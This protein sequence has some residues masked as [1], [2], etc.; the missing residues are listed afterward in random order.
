MRMRTLVAVLVLAIAT[1]LS[2]APKNDKPKERWRA[3]QVIVKYKA[4]FA[5]AADKHG[6]KSA[7]KV[8]G[9][10]KLKGKAKQHAD[11]RGLD[12]IYVLNLKK[13]DVEATVAALKNDPAVEYA[14]P[15]WTLSF[16]AVP[17][18]PSY[19]SQWGLAK[20]GAPAAWDTATSGMGVVVGVVDTGIDLTHPDLA[21]NL[22]TNAGEIAGNNIDDDGNGFVDD[23]HGFDFYADHG[24]PID[25]HG[26]GTMVAGVIGA[27]GNNATGVSGVVW[28]ARLAALKIGSD[29]DVHAAVQAIEY[30]NMMGFRITSNSWGWNEG[31]QSF[32]LDDVIAAA[33][34]AGHLFV[35]AA[36]NDAQN[37][38]EFPFYPS[39]YTNP[40]VISVTATTSSDALASFANYGFT[41]VDLAAPGDGI[42][43]TNAGGGYTTVSGTSLSAPFV[44]GA[45][46]LYWTT[47]PSLT[48]AAVRD[49]LM[50]R[51][52]PLPALNGRTVSGGRLNV[53]NLFDSDAVAPDAITDLTV[54]DFTHRS[55][56]VRF[57][58]TGDDGA[59][60]RASRY[61][62]RVSTSP[63][64]A[65]SFAT[66]TPLVGEPIPA[67]PA[68]LETFKL[69]GIQPSTVYYIA[70]KALDNAGNAGALSNV[71]TFTTPRAAVL[72]DDNFEGGARD[73]TVEGTDGIGGPSLWHLQA[74][75][76]GT[77]RWQYA[78]AAGYGTDYDTGARNWGALVSRELDLTQARDTRL[79]FRQ[80]VW[81]ER[82]IGR[83]LAQVQVSV[84]GGAWTTILAKQFTGYEDAQ[85]ELDLSAYDGQ[86]IRIR[87]FIDTVDADDNAHPGWTLDDV[88][89]DATSAN[90]PPSVS[91]NAI[92]AVTEDQGATLSATGNDPE[93]A[94]LE[95]KW[96]FGDGK[97]AYTTQSSVAH[98]WTLPGNYTVTVTAYDGS[99]AS[100]AATAAVVPIA[101]NDRPVAGIE[102]GFATPP[103]YEDTPYTI[104]WFSSSDE[105]DDPLTCRFDY[106][107][108]TTDSRPCD[109]SWP[110]TWGAPGVYTI[111]LV[112]NDG[113]LD[114]L[115]DT[116]QITIL[117]LS[118]DKPVART[119][120][121]LDAHPNESVTF[122]GTASTDEETSVAS[123]LWNFGDGT[124]A[125]TATAQ[126]SFSTPGVK[127]VSLVV[128][129]QTG[130]ASN[131]AST[132][133]RVCGGASA[134]L[135][136]ST[137]YTCPGAEA[138][139][140]INV[141]SGI[142]P[143]TITW[144]DGYTQEVTSLFNGYYAERIVTP[145]TGGS[146][147]LASI[148]DFLGCAGTVNTAPAPVVVPSATLP[149]TTRHICPGQST[150]IEPQLTG[151]KPWTLTW[152]DG[153]VQTIPVNGDARRT[154]A[155]AETTVYTITSATCAACAPGTSPNVSG[156]MTVAV[157]EP[158]AAVVSGGGAS[159]NG[160][161]VPVTVTITG[162][163]PPFS[164][165]W[166][167]AN[168]S[169][170]TSSRTY[171]TFVAPA[172][173]TTYT[174]RV[175]SGSCEVDATGS[176]TVT[177]W[178]G[179][180]PK[181]TAVTGGQSI[182]TGGSATLTAT[183]QGDGP[184]TLTWSDGFVQTVTGTA[185]TRNV[186]PASST[187]YSVASIVNEAGC[188]GTR[189][190]ST[191]VSVAAPPT[192]LVRGGGNS[193]SG[194]TRRINVDL[195]GIGPYTITWS[196]GVTETV[197]SSFFRDLA[198]ATTT[199]YSLTSVTDSRC[200]GTVSGSATINVSTPVSVSVT[201]GGPSCAGAPV[202]VNASISGGTAPYTV[203]WS[204]GFVQTV[205][206]PVASR[207]VTV[208]QTTSFS[209]TSINSI[210]GTSIGGSATVWNATAPTAVVSGGGTFC[211]GSNATLIVQLS[212]GGPYN[213]TWSDGFTQT[214]STTFFTRQVSPA[215]ATTYTITSLSNSTCS[216][217]SSGSATATPTV[218]TAVVSGG[219]E[220]CNGAPATL[221]A[222]LS[223]QGLPFTLTWS[224]GYVQTANSLTATR[225]VTPG[226]PTTYTLTSVRNANGCNGTSSGSAVVTP[227]APLSAAVSGGGAVCPGGSASIT[228]S[229]TGE[230]GP[231]T[232]TWSDGF[233]QTASTSTAT[234]SV[235]P[236]SSTTYSVSSIT[237]A[238]G[239]IG[240]ASGSASVSVTP[241][242]AAVVSGGGT[243]C[244]GGTARINV[245]LTGVGPFT[246]TWANGTTETVA[247]SF[248]RDLAPA[249][250]TTYSLTAVTDSRCSGT[251]S[252][253][254]TITP[255]TPV[256]VTVSGGGALC[257]NT[258]STIT[259]TIS[260]GSAP[261]TLTW[262]DGVTQTVSGTTATRQVTVAT[263][264]TFT[265][266]AVSPSS[267]GSSFGG[268]ATVVPRP[269]P[270][271]TVSGGG[272]YCSGGTSTI[273]AALT[274]TAPFTVTWSDGVVQTV[275][276]GTTGTRQVT[277]SSSTVYTVTSL[278]DTYCTGG[279]S[280][281][282]ATVTP[283]TPVSVTVS[284][285]G[286]ICTGGSA[287][288][289]ATIT[290]AGLPATLTWS[291][292]FV[293]NA[294]TSIV[295]RSVSPGA[296][297][298]YSVS[299]ITNTNGCA[300]TTSG[301]ATV[302]PSAAPTALV[303]GGGPSCSGGGSVVYV[304]LTGVGPFTITWTGGATET[305]AGSFFRVFAPA[306]ATTY[307]I[308][309]I[310][311]SRCSGTS[312][313]NATV[314]PS[315]AVSVTVSGGGYSC[316]NS[317]ATVTATISG[318][319][320]PYTLTWE[321]G[322]VQQVSGTVATRQVTV[323]STTTYRVTAVS[324][325]CGSSIGGSA[326][327]F[328]ATAPTAV[329]SG[330]GTFC[331]GTTKAITA[332]L[333]GTAPFTVT[334]SDGVV[335]TINSGTTA[336][337]NV[338]PLVATTYTATVSDASC[339]GT[340]SGSAVVTPT[341]KPV[342]TTQPQSKTIAK[343]TATT[344]TVAT[345]ESGL[346]YQWY[347]GASGTTTLPVGTNSSSFT[348]PKLTAN[349]QYWVKIWKTACASYP[350]N[351]ATATITVQ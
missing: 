23:V 311:D 308:S 158:L 214:A 99:T 249:V 93:G 204:D 59:A 316:P 296:A 241:P 25:T 71:A 156:N 203:T 202:T 95:Y 43:T 36:G 146:Y 182:C 16:D 53:A 271:A 181:V 341:T 150:M 325:S 30:A 201:G 57:T 61:D 78:K 106:G 326:T 243:S 101:V 109:G 75:Y 130:L 290:G 6:V 277:P 114:S 3:G 153:Y 222:E 144:A 107:D 22:W 321:D 317:P 117:E 50:L 168:F 183:L 213:I 162:G 223:G 20:I 28:S 10:F 294:A 51:S 163:E 297:T 255:S 298:T 184:L 219:G 100:D 346:S 260:G 306:A 82:N 205:P 238:T 328:P 282:S 54:T 105:E 14:E 305:V 264:T 314:T 17:N 124:T 207:Q 56:T 288:V 94:P 149:N 331:E 171:T 79:R 11:A 269:T 1:S 140:G 211:P 338:A 8:F 126:K 170:S 265:V 209:V 295:T 216:G 250:A 110:H 47:N 253:S 221:I 334:W 196:D 135:F 125:T 197:S 76:L 227:S 87:F 9:K 154:V 166:A 273:S 344:L 15:N 259:A 208:A 4:G 32:L 33:E 237:N 160:G 86:Q 284:G 279:T 185:A 102:M 246:I 27:A 230:N 5:P 239:C 340:S 329:V 119:N 289:T 176:A 35:A 218:V 320:A 141:T 118:N 41:S 113:Q 42:Y 31:G 180:A 7:K 104:A 46:A 80:F 274:G 188:T 251:V 283:S 145:S 72:F 111:T 69:S 139:L 244:S 332:T 310:S 336:T 37:N 159:C 116:R 258:T 348:T 169:V 186:S 194:A 228:A 232:I 276:S 220:S 164:I 301:S 307:S 257:P 343:K 148:T 173:V 318:G 29:P 155:P 45:A 212:G 91:L 74:V 157:M 49:A 226:S 193:C 245:A 280:S 224:D 323:T 127:N 103:N 70:A 137:I 64:T 330:T 26:H 39:H 189:T 65:A 303:H 266:T 256:S 67:L 300:G 247:S 174:A 299:S 234:R 242:P 349:T 84:G 77:N 136:T 302:T 327:V 138:T 254:A 319:T 68:T 261:Y 225:V 120:G 123:Y 108:G 275:A 2:A 233:V 231:F 89:V 24:N 73:W 128:T 198:P 333:T 97:F 151:P 350:T 210:C 83:D 178:T 263:S 217:T 309:S 13:D 248:Y 206:G 122:D 215:A 229:I 293:Q 143:L 285:G 172:A 195:T 62:V 192:A 81:M 179:V 342:I 48:P 191:F 96:S 347:Q 236:S 175:S 272:T 268:S 267:C 147:A 287:T 312:S 262:S 286:A 142:L 134:S 270:T 121:P 190:G 18:D 313:G 34:A 63:I 292:G 324:S 85:E 199:T 38:D 55:V 177:P 152:S 322:L 58:A 132:Q 129:D 235:S 304:D 131:P 12:R 19:A 60:G 112:V 200:S 88:V 252:G 240:T 281:G 278:R 335:Q 315:S 90:A 66:A 337:R 40:N 291:D 339:T 345:T 165:T 351:S 115:P 161:S 133:V 187:T 21:A 92:P 167:G 44:A 98:T 52:D